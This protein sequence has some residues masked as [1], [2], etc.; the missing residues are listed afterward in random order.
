MPINLSLQKFVTSGWPARLN[1]RWYELCL[2]QN[3]KNNLENILA[4][5]SQFESMLYSNTYL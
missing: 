1:V 4:G 3:F 5:L 2:E